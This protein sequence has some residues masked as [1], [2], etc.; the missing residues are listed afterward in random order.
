MPWLRDLLNR[1]RTL[2]SRDDKVR[3]PT[4]VPNAPEPAA[5]A[6]RACLQ[7]V[8]TL[9]EFT[10]AGELIEA[11]YFELQRRHPHMDRSVVWEEMLEST[12]VVC[13]GC[14]Q[15]LSKEALGSLAVARVARMGKATFFG[16]PNVAALTEGRCPGCGDRLAAVQFGPDKAGRLVGPDGRPLS[17]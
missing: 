8:T 7:Q 16:G 9:V 17:K 6:T 2:Y 14:E 11:L 15:F 1:L 4:P 13:A 3:P 5:W 12:T 10:H